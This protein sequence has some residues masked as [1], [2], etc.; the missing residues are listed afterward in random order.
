M[1]IWSKSSLNDFYAFALSGAVRNHLTYSAFGE[2]TNQ[3][4]PSV[5]TQF[6]YTGREFEPATGLQYNRGRFY[7]PFTGKFLS[8]DPIGFDSGDL[9]LY[10]YVGNSPIDEIDPLGETGQISRFSRR[11]NI[12]EATI[13]WKDGGYKDDRTAPAGGILITSDLRKFDGRLRL[14]QDP[15]DQ[16]H[17]IPAQ[18][19]GSD[20]TKIVPFSNNFI[21]QDPLVNRGAYNQFGQRVNERLG[22]Y[23]RA[24][25]EECRYRKGVRDAN[26][27]NI[28]GA[29][30]GCQ[31]ALPQ[32]PNEPFIRYTV[33][34]ADP[35]LKNSSNKVS[36]ERKIYEKIKRPEKL[37][38][39]ATFYL[40]R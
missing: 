25:K 22:E 5:T 20:K 15:E 27:L 23:Y 29:F 16:G 39:Q 6:G 8:P 24:Y 26:P 21:S 11:G 37:N 36:L 3:S 13:K 14:R 30:C 35:P 31:V 19:G 4:D 33:A 34:L 1:L 9:N 17:L 2:L 7:A 18:L 40:N 10:R 32:D 28:F 38:V 12:A